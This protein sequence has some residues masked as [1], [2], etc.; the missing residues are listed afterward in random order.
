MSAADRELAIDR[1]EP[2]QIVMN[3]ET[4]TVPYRRAVGLVSLGRAEWYVES[5]AKRT[6]KSV[7]V[8]ERGSE[9]KNVPLQ[10]ASTVP[11]PAKSEEAAETE[12][13][14]SPSDP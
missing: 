7:P 9:S 11:S 2:V 3:G 6:R 14:P 8:S 10:S 13:Q 4:Q 12:Y 1:A 5:K